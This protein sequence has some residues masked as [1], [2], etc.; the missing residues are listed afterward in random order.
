[1]RW[2]G[3]SKAGIVHREVQPGAERKPGTAVCRRCGDEKPK[4]AFALTASGSRSSVCIECWSRDNRERA[5]RCNEKKRA[6][7][8]DQ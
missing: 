8:D 5:N 3:V 2:Y 1:M 6:R 7:K 4:G